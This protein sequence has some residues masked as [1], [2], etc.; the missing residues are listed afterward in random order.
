MKVWSKVRLSF[1]EIMLRILM[2]LVLVLG[3]GV[4]V[5]LVVGI[6]QLLLQS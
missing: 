4:V 1:E 2:V 3:I 5:L 6:R